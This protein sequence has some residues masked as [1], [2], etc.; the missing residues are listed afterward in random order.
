MRNILLAGAAMLATTSLAM[1]AGSDSVAISTT[2]AESCSVNITATTVT[3]PA[4]ATP[5]ST[6][7]FTFTCNYTGTSAALTYTSTNGG[8]G[9]NANPYN[10]ITLVGNDGTSAAPLITGSLATTALTP[11][12][13]SFTLQLQTPILVAGT[14]SDTL[15]V[16][17]AP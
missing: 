11:V 15:T 7:P 2:V 14:Y 10:I 3:L 17:V 9:S 12:N 4:D 5:S 13:N 8:A 16:S 1:A 6:V